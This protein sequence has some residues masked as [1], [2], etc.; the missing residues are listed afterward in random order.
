MSSLLVKVVLALATCSRFLAGGIGLLVK[1]A[2][3]CASGLLAG[4]LPLASTSGDEEYLILVRPQIVDGGLPIPVCVIRT[5]ASP[6]KNGSPALLQRQQSG[7]LLVF[8]DGS[9]KP[10]FEGSRSTNVGR[11]VVASVVVEQPLGRA[12]GRLRPFELQPPGRI[13]EGGRGQMS[14]RGSTVLH[15]GRIR[16]GI[17]C[18]FDHSV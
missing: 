9:L 4:G 5:S 10:F 8:A 13:G 3:S 17:V 14:R 11:G 6:M 1:K 18:R 16:E 15:L 2:V 7:S 12:W